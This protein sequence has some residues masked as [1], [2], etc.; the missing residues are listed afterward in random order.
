MSSAASCDPIG[1]RIAKPR[2]ATVRAMSRPNRRP[3]LAA[4]A[5][6]IASHARAGERQVEDIGIALV[7]RRFLD[8]QA[9]RRGDL[10]DL[11]LGGE[12]VLQ[13]ARRRR[14]RARDARS[15]TPAATRGRRSGA[16]PRPRGTSP[17]RAPAPPRAIADRSTIAAMSGSPPAAPGMDGEAVELAEL[18]R[19]AVQH[20]AVAGLEP[21]RVR[22]FER[23]DLPAVG[24]HADRFLRRDRPHV[25]PEPA[26]DPPIAD[27]EPPARFP[28]PRRP[29]PSGPRPARARMRRAAPRGPRRGS[30]GRRRSRLAPAPAKGDD[31]FS[32]RVDLIRPRIPR[33]R[34][35]R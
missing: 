25:G 2:S 21:L 27:A 26:D 22:A 24:H 1:R 17:G 5:R 28:D 10:A 33:R 9:A 30:R 16:A 34:P 12:Q 20:E 7:V 29:S 32:K 23:A 6:P 14:V 3:S 15:A 4:T 31:F 19:P 18:Q 13:H 8:Q 35:C 11:L